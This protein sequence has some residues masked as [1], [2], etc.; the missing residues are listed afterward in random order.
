VAVGDLSGDG[1]PDLAVANL[2]SNTVSVFLGDGA[3]GFGAGT[4][5]DTGVNPYSVAIGDLSGDGRPDLAVANYG[6]NSVSV[7][8]GTGAGGFAARTDFAAGAS[9][10]AVVIGDLNADLRP[11]LVVTNF[12]DNT[13]SVLR[14]D[15]AGGSKQQGEHHDVG[16]GRPDARNEWREGDPPKRQVESTHDEVRRHD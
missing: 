13:V 8:L 16:I 4:D 2:G 11:D 6:S 1:W 5:F 14:G 15:G 7:L 10:F 12:Q 9:P 3:G